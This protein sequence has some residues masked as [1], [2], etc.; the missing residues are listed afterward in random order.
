MAN[1]QPEPIVKPKQKIRPRKDKKDNLGQAEEWARI[2]K[3]DLDKTIVTPQASERG[4]AVTPLSV[5][6]VI[7]PPVRNHRKAKE[8]ASGNLIAHEEMNSHSRVAA[9]S[10]SPLCTGA[11]AANPFRGEG[12]V[13]TP[14]LAARRGKRRQGGR[15][16]NPRKPD[17]GEEGRGNAETS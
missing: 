4:G 3:L 14:S 9:R 13:P 12:G 10:K 7:S 15:K 5:N 11:G 17:K 1:V 6:P 16:G 8:L 2:S